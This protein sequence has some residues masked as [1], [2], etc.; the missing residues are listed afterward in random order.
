[1][2][3]L[4]PE[5]RVRGSVDLGDGRA[6]ALRLA[7]AIPDTPL[8]DEPWLAKLLTAIEG[9]VI[10]RLM[11]AHRNPAPAAALDPVPDGSITEAHVAEL[12]IIAMR[13]GSAV[14]LSYVEA[15]RA[16]QATLEQ[17]YMEL[18]GP[19]AQRLGELWCQD[20]VDFGAVTLG[21]NALESVLRELG[22]EFSASGAPGQLR[23]KVILCPADR[24]QHTFGL[25][26]VGDFLR[27]D[28]WQVEH[29]QRID[30]LA[31][32]AADEW[33]HAVGLSVSCS[34]HVEALSATIRQLRRVSMNRDVAVIV[35]GRLFVEQPDLVA[36]VGADAMALDGRHAVQQ[37]RSV[38]RLLGRRS[39]SDR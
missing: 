30:A 27:R 11:L 12:A 35:G 10:P 21:L 36:R 33:V 4:F 28:G 20:L 39:A 26:M 9:E 17:L 1:M 25:H 32:R 5:G 18:L 13:H 23:G 16:Q 24:E 8:Q 2:D 3:A 31:Q 15:L 6:S 7:P 29:E 38:R 34:I 22:P 37:L 19:A 14:A